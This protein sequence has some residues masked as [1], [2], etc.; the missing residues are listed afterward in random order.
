MN[1][2]LNRCMTIFFLSL[3]KI[4][5]QSII[6]RIL[7]FSLLALFP[8]DL[9]RID[10]IIISPVIPHVQIEI[11]SLGPLIPPEIM[12]L[13]HHRVHAREHL[14]VGHLDLVLGE[15]EAVGAVEVAGD[16]E[17][18]GEGNGSGVVHPVQAAA[19]VYRAFFNSSWFAATGAGIIFKE[20]FVQFCVQRMLKSWA[21][22]I[23]GV[24][25]LL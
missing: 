20:I 6:P 5:K 13:P 21:A 17:D 10:I 23:F 12:D 15:E 19:W 8:L 11:L 22:L 4:G 18:E 25:A 2:Q 24:L 9:E 14:P 3:G 7:I 1:G 16:L